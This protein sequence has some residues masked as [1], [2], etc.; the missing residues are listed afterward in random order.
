MDGTIAMAD[1]PEYESRRV[2]RAAP[3]VRVEEVERASGSRFI[4]A[5]WVRPSDDAPEERFDPTKPG[6]RD[7]AAVGHYAMLYPDGFKSICPQKAFEEGYTRK[8]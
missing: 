5:I 7:T 6:M 2:V 3:I 8:S 1:W 4:K